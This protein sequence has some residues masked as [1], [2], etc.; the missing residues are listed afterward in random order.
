MKR[1]TNEFSQK[2]GFILRAGQGSHDSGKWK[3]KKTPR[4]KQKSFLFGK[5]KAIENVIDSFIYL[6]PILAL[7]L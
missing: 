5:L 3:G 1:Y 4:I 7:N 6:F 2:E